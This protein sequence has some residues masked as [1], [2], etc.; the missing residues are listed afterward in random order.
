MKKNM[1]IGIFFVMAFA[2]CV[3]CRPNKNTE[4]K[5][6]VTVS[7]SGTVSV[8]PDIATLDFSVTKS[9]WESK[10]VVPE[11]AAIMNKVI[12]AIKESGVSQSDIVTSEVSIRQDKSW[13]NG[14][15]RRGQYVSTNQVR[16]TLR[17]LELLGKLIDAAVSAGA[18]GLDSLSFGVSD[19]QTAMR[20]ARTAAIKQ[21][22][23]AA[24]LLAGASGC[25]LGQVLSI[26]EGGNSGY[27]RAVYMKADSYVNT[28]TPI[29]VGKISISSSVTMSFELQ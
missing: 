9:G 19:T 22:Q 10:K 13:Q 20:Q 18:N 7:G 16:V 8:T 28:S 12:D 11:N 23:D 14:V 6:V 3:S 4:Q 1:G 17:N 2:L 27:E 15:L 24:A 25:K 26:D 21:A 5:R 29:E